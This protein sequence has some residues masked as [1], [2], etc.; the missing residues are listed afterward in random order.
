[1]PSS[2]IAVAGCALAAMWLLILTTAP[3]VDM[4][5]QDDGG[6]WAGIGDVEIDEVSARQMRT[7]AGG[8]RGSASARE[9][10]ACRSCSP[11]ASAHSH[12][13]VMPRRTRGERCASSRSC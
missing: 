8:G 10:Q 2:R 9:R 11:A 13:I 3:S 6:W 7:A 12:G 5:P 1:M 4:A